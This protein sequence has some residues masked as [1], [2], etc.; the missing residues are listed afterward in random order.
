MYN[1]FLV[2]LGGFLGANARYLISSLTAKHIDPSL[3]WGTLAVNVS[4]SFV[5][6]VFLAWTTE[7]VLA[8]PA[9]RLLVAVG[10]C[11]A[12]TTFSSFAFETVRLVEQGH[13]WAATGNFF[14]N[15]VLSLMGVIAG[16][17]IARWI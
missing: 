10:F 14:M 12:F 7:R 1:F 4:G 11:G 13:L 9:Y 8:D 2:G 16:I 17:A 6:G 5:I 15:N 3:P